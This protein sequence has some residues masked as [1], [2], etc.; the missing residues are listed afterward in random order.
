LTYLFS[1]IDRPPLA[2]SYV[3]LIDTSIVEDGFFNSVIEILKY[4]FTNSLI[5]DRAK[6]AIMTYEANVAS[7]YRFIEGTKQTQQ[8]CVGEPFLPLPVIFNLIIRK[9]SYL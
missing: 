6:V 2:P 7:Y 4:I 1:Y 8:L 9:I 3:F 5:N